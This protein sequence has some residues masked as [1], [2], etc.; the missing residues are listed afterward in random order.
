[1]SGTPGGWAPRRFW[2]E[3]GVRPE[4]GG[5]A[6]ALDGRPIRTPGRAPL[7]V[8]T[9]AFAEAVAAEWDAQG[10]VV[11]PRSMPATRL[12]NTAIDRVA[13]H[14]GAVVDMVAAYGG[15]DLLCYRAE[16][17][18]LAAR[19]REGWDPL[20]A[21]AAEAF[22]AEL[23]LAEGVMPVDQPA[24]A[25]GRLR[26]RVAAMGPFPLSA[27][28]DLVTLT[29]SLVLG[30]A[31]AEGRIGPEEG[32]RL[33]R[34]DEDFQAGEWGEVE[35]AVEMAALRERAYRDAARLWSLLRPD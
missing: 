7:V 4:G 19:Q 23:R 25:L 15:T 34:I 16:R 29:G 27:F 26:A 2:R 35:E 9:R 17:A 30:L 28:H 20:L 1:V 5:F 8:P 14:H 11:D 10:E 6:V 31:V 32:W 12:S 18:A 3:A 33:S 21:W 24:E 13:H 22:G